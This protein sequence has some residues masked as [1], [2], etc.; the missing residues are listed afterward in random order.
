MSLYMPISA[1]AFVPVD[2][3]VSE[4]I[5]SRLME[6]QNDD[7]FQQCQIILPNHK[8]HIRDLTIENGSGYPFIY[9]QT[10]AGVAL[11]NHNYSQEGVKIDGRM[12]SNE[13]IV[14]SLTCSIPVPQEIQERYRRA[15]IGNI[16]TI[17]RLASQC[18]TVLSDL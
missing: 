14:T 5:E 9:T 1:N 13:I 15:G 17:Q 10:A 3:L 18:L 16:E 6:L 4:L 2:P 7:R 8:L 12:T 11:F